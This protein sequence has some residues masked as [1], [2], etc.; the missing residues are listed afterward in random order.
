MSAGI[1]EIILEQGATFTRTIVYKDENG[2]PIDLTSV[3]SITG[4][5]RPSYSSSTSIAFVLAIV[6][7][8]TNGEISWS[9]SAVNS[10]LLVPNSPQ[11]YDIEI[12]YN[13]GVVD[14]ILQGNVCVHPQVTR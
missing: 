14:R 6:G 3:T 1:L 10:A 13:S 5:I 2:A 4:Q 8:P 7:A 11:V 12:L 9:M